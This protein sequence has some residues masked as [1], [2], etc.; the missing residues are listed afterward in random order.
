MRAYIINGLPTGEANVERWDSASTACKSLQLEC[1]RTPAVYMNM[2][3]YTSACNDHSQSSP[4]EK[5]VRGCMFAH[6]LA[7][8][9]IAD[10]NERSIILEDDIVVP[11]ESVERVH[12]FL[13]DSK[14]ADVAYVGHCF[15]TQ[16]MHAIAI[17]PQAAHKALARIDWCGKTPVD[18]QL[19]AMC[20]SGELRCVYAPSSNE[21]PDAWGNGLILQKRGIEVRNTDWFSTV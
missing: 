12:S 20:L 11:E 3:V 13:T 1:E 4:H 15:E 7:F 21:Q 9:K 5:Y 18:N 6:K 14:D 8:Q 17:T 10:A 19:S 16:C 2:N